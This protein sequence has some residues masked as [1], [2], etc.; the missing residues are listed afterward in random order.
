[1]ADIT[2]EEKYA[3]KAALLKRALVEADEMDAADEKAAAANAKKRQG[4][5]A[6]KDK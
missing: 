5:A 6:E 3:R 1:M 4:R 2:E